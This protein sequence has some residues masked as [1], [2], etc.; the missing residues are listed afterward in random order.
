MVNTGG[1]AVV[2]REM[3]GHALFLF[4]SWG[5]DGIKHWVSFFGGNL[6]FYLARQRG[7]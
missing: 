1:V 4:H 7:W 6:H 2:G 5:N 3:L